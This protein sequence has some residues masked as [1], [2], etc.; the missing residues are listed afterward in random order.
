M[1]QWLKNIVLDYLHGA[2]YKYHDVWEDRVYWLLDRGLLRRL[3]HKVGISRYNF[4]RKNPPP[5]HGC[6]IKGADYEEDW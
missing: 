2:G 4:G 1:R 6:V 3:W 5:E